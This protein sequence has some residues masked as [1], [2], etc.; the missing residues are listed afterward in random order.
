LNNEHTA[1]TNINHS[2]SWNFDKTG[3]W[4]QYNLNGNIENRTHNAANELQNIAAHDANGNMTLMPNLKGKYDAW[5]R[6]IEARD[7]SDNLITQYEYNALNQRIKKTVGATIIQSFFNENWQELE[8]VTNNQVTNYVWGLRYI[9]DLILREKGNEKLYSIAD[10][11][12]NIIALIDSTGNIAE[13]MK[14]DAFGKITWLDENFNEKSNSDYSWNRTFTGQV[15]DIETGLMLYRNRYYHVDLGRFVSRDPIGYRE[16]K[17]NLLTYVVNNPIIYQDKLGLKKCQNPP[18]PNGCGGAGSW[19]VVP[20]YYFYFIDFTAACNA[21]DICYAT[22]GK[23]KS[24]CDGLFIHDMLSICQHYRNQW[25]SPLNWAMYDTCGS[26]AAAY[27]DA[28]WMVGQSY[29]DNA[30]KVY[31]P[32]IPDGACCSKPNSPPPPPPPSPP[33]YW[34]GT[35]PL[36]L[37]Y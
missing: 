23:T 13:R 35:I 3:N 17:N 30:Q 26:I 21:H 25:W 28:V 32:E 18:N 4:Q 37:I 19:D 31:C 2:E 36:Y 24:E 16:D 33:P 5:N 22:C 15:L 34:D 29:Y 14:Y 27:Y 9:D 7:S 6:L 1:V 12:W 11:N 20:D 10:P 8:S